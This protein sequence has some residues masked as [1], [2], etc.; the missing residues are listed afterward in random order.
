MRQNK[1]VKCKFCDEDLITKNFSRHLERNHSSESEVIDLLRYPKNSR[2]RRRAFVL[3]RNE[4]NFSLYIN[5]IT[6]PNRQKLKNLNEKEVYYPCAYCKGLYLREYLK[7]HSGRCP[8]KAKDK[9]IKKCHI[10]ASQTVTA[11]AMDTT[12]IISKL[13]VKTQV[14]FP[15]PKIIF[16]LKIR[17]Q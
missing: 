16:D 8:V 10:S 15:L 14:S 4:T 1:K 11:C 9:N 17:V 2:E 3:F 7:R 6:R 12:N 13:N 5:G